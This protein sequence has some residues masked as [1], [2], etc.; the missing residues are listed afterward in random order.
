MTDET[1]KAMKKARAERKRA[2]SA[3]QALLGIYPFDG[4]TMDRCDAARQC[5]ETAICMMTVDIDDHEW[6]VRLGGT[7]SR[8]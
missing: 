8:G 1:Y 2:L 7:L 6:K 5:C 3:L 4:H